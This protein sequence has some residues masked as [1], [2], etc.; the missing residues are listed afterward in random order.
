MIELTEEQRIRI[1]LA[2]KD[3]T[4]AQ[5]E[6]MYLFFIALHLTPVINQDLVS[7]AESHFLEG[8]KLLAEAIEKM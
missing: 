3:S 7:A 5:L 4:N 2:V 8:F 6:S 1:K